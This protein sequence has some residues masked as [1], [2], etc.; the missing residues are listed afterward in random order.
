MKDSVYAETLLN[1]DWGEMDNDQAFG[2]RHSIRPRLSKA[3]RADASDAPAPP[4][5]V[6][7]KRKPVS[8]TVREA[9]AAAQPSDEPYAEAPTHTNTSETPTKTIEAQEPRDHAAPEVAPQVTQDTPTVGQGSALGMPHVALPE[10]DADHWDTLPVAQAGAR[11]GRG[12]GIPV[13]DLARDTASHRAFDLLRTRLRQTTQENKWVNIAITA[14]TSGCGTTFTAVNLALSLSRVAQSRT[15]LMDFNLRNPSVM[16][17]IDTDAPGEMHAYLTGGVPV[18]QHL[19]RLSDTLALGLNAQADQ[20][21]SETLQDVRTH[22]TLTAM[23][24]MLKPELV[25]YDMP[26]MLVHDDVSAFLPHLDGVLLV[27]DGTQTLAKQLLECE[28]MLEGQV[29]LLG[30]VLNRARKSSIPKY[31]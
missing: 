24:D 4:T 12:R 16:D 5:R 11:K 25:I 7:A 15:V 20:N 10:I 6:K 13:V 28:R 2:M 23:Q 21:A 22:E 19:V 29:P 31:S 1:M 30:V 26:A 27:S 17:A 18:D 3:E 8:Q 9:L 14:P